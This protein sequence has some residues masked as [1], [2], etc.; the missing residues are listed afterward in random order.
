MPTVIDALVVTLGLDAKDYKKGS[1]EAKQAQDDLLQSAQG[2][3]AK[4][5]AVQN[6]SGKNEQKLGD[7]RKRESDADRRRKQDAEQRA[8]QQSEAE[9]KRYDGTIDR[10]KSIGLY[11]GAALLGFD[12]LKGAI[13]AYADTTN[14]LAQTGRFAPTVGASVKEVQTLSNALQQVG[15]NA[16]DAQA[17]LAKLGHA[18]FSYRMGAPDAL[19][20]YAMRAGIS[21]FDSQGKERD[22]LAILQDVGK[23]IR[24]MTPD[25][26]AQ[27][28]YAREMGLSEAS[29][30]LYVLEEAKTREKILKQSEAAAKADERRAKAA[31]DTVSAWARIKN[32]ITGVKQEIVGGT[33]P[34]VARIL[35]SIANAGERGPTVGAEGMAFQ[36]RKFEG[37]KPF[38]AAF[39]SAEKKYGL[40]AGFL[41]NVAHQESNFNPN[42]RSGK[43]AV[44]LMQL[45]PQYFPGAGQ[46]TNRDIDTAAKEL[47]R[48][49]KSYR[50]MYSQQLALTMAVAAYNAGQGKVNHVIRGD[51]DPKTGKP[52]T[53]SKET[54]NYVPSVLSGTHAH[55]NFAADS[56]APAGSAGGSNSTTNV[57]IGSIN[58][59]APQARDAGQIAGEIAPAL[60]RKGVVAQANAGMS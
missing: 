49:Y 44:G 15:G 22:K 54:A 58:I 25:R 29:I 40:P 32:Q 28:M 46:D 6:K 43:G 26:Q 39:S 57:E 20:G 1:A 2:N 56:V 52:H 14:Q 59:N 9:K 8:R 47:S 37:A 5:E 11:A 41:A 23:Q 21:L 3:A 51:I 38:E 27:A 45:M 48:L 18:Q 35:N 50:K 30:Q 12:S 13:S 31:Q 17:D 10:L 34:G 60:K 53:L 19:A 4:V 16:Q 55:E 33:A 24:A 42:A 7:T 36:A